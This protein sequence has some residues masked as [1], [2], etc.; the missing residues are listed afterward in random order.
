MQ[1][2]NLVFS[3]MPSFLKRARCIMI[4]DERQT[5]SRENKSDTDERTYFTLT[6]HVSLWSR[7]DRHTTNMIKHY[8][9]HI[10]SS[11]LRKMTPCFISDTPLALTWTTQYRPWAFTLQNN[12]CCPTVIYHGIRK[13]HREK[14]IVIKNV[15]YNSIIFCIKILLKYTNN[16]L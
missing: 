3:L 8:L 9:G 10:E 11:R 13:K 6:P 16:L 2:N 15:P 5:K 4:T 12:N 1:T 7:C 14:W